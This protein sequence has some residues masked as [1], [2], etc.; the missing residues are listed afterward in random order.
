MKRFLIPLLAVLALPTTV[1]AN[2]FGYGSSFE[3]MT[4]CRSWEYKNKKR[5]RRCVRDGET[6]QVIGIEDTK[7]KKRFK[8]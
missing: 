2:W 8:Y 3:A 5:F 4:A 7:V 1:E 6:N